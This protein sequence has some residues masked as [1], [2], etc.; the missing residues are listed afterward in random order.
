MILVEGRVNDSAAVFLLDT[1]ATRTIVSA[2]TYGDLPFRLRGA[3]RNSQG[4]GIAGESVALTV[5]LELAN[6]MWAG[7]GVAVMNLD[8]LDQLLGVRFDGLLGQDILSEFHTVRI[9][10]QAHIVELEE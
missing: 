4:A 5:N 10:Y 2:R 1:G 6:H 8:G 3:Q 7:Q 9:D